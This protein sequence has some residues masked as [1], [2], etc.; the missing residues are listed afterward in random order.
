MARILI[1]DDSAT[2]RH[3][4]RGMLERN[5]FETL[6][7]DSGQQALEMALREHPDLILMDVVMPGMNGFQATRQLGRTPET[8]AIPVVLV[9][10]K[11]QPVDRIWGLRQGAR[12]Y[13]VKPVDE[14][15]LVRCMRAQLDAS[16]TRQSR[17]A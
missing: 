11:D 7:A 16:D 13:L 15:S 8:A 9:S 3:Q 4:L 17:P 5:G 12:E 14:S 2:A 1:A 6:A 10:S